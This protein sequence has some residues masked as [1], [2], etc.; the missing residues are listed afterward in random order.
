V[1][2]ASTPPPSRDRLH[3]RH[4]NPSGAVTVAIHDRRHGNFLLLDFDE[5]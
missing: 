1:I 2:S 3:V 4:W 5:D